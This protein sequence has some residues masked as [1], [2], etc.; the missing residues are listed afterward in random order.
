MRN[1]LNSLELIAGITYLV[2]ASFHI[3]WSMEE[4]PIVT[5]KFEGKI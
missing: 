4:I 1:F 5:V 3:D 2:S